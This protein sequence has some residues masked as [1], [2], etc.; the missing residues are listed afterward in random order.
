MDDYRC[1]P[2]ESPRL[3]C[4]GCRCLVDMKD[5]AIIMRTSYHLCP[6]GA[7]PCGWCPAHAALASKSMQSSPSIVDS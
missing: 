3:W 6:K 2:E 5:S 4:L 7:F 1:N